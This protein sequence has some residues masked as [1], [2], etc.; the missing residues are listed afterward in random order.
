MRTVVF[1]IGS[2]IGSGSREQIELNWLGGC[3][4]KTSVLEGEEN[5]EAKLKEST[6]QISGGPD[7]PLSRGAGKTKG[8]CTVRE[9]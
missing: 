2:S 9:E 5:R 3:R 4:H 1:G 6:A 7:I 8:Y